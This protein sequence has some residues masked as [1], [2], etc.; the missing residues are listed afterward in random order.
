MLLGP[1]IKNTKVHLTDG[2]PD[3]YLPIQVAIRDGLLD[4]DA[5]HFLCTYHGFEQLFKRNVTACNL[6]DEP[7]LKQGY[8]HLRQW[9]YECITIA[10]LERSKSMFWEWFELDDTKKKIGLEKHKKLEDFVR[11][12]IIPNLP[13]MALPFRLYHR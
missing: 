5:A 10:E 3:E 11:V 7:T 13:M 4:K 12:S 1:I 9:I 6:D 2:D 8:E